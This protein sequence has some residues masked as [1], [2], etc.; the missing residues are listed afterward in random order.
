MRAF[1]EK[2]VALIPQRNLLSQITVHGPY[3]SSKLIIARSLGVSAD[4]QNRRRPTNAKQLCQGCGQLRRRPSPTSVFGAM[5]RLMGRAGATGSFRARQPLVTQTRPRKV[6]APNGHSTVII[7]TV[8]R[9]PR[10]RTS[11]AACFRK[12]DTLN[13]TAAA[14]RSTE[15]WRQTLSSSRAI[16]RKYLPVAT[17]CR[18]RRAAWSSLQEAGAFRPDMCKPETLTP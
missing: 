12:R 1:P 14:I 13:Y 6:G 3:G 7:P 4:R 15:H 9:S 17:L 18:T 2:L 5:T 16:N 10:R 8:D 11:S